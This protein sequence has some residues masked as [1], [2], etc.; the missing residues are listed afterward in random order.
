MMRETGAS[1]EEERLSDGQISALSPYGTELRLEEGD[2]L[3]DEESVVDSFYVVLEG[4]IRISRLDGAAE[5]TLVSHSPG[6]FTGGLATLTGR[7]SVHRARAAVPS[8]VLEIDSETFR[9]VAVEIPDAADVFI[10]VLAQRMRETH[11]ALRQQE[12]LAALGRLSAG[13]AHE[14]NNPAAAAR[15][16]SEGL[17]ET[18]LAAQ[19]NA[20]R[21]DRRFSPAQREALLAL[22]REATE[23]GPAPGLDPLEQSDREEELALWLEER[24]VDEAWDLA[25][26]LAAAGLDTGRMETLEGEFDVGTLAGGLGWLGATLTV[27]ALAEEVGQSA[28]RI[29]ELVAAI[30]D[31]TQM[32]RSQ[33]S[34]ETDVRE[35]IES[36][37]TILGHRLRSI[38]V[39][40]EY[41]QE[42][43]KVRARGGELNQVWSNLIG[44]AADAVSLRDG[45]HGSIGVGA[46][47]DGANHVLVEIRDDG[48]GIPPEIRGRIFEPFFTTRDVGEGTGLGLDIARRAIAGHGGEIDFESR[49]GDTRF[50]VR[51]PVTEKRG[52]PD[53]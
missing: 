10:S 50:R 15:R 52:E 40:R 24:G 53:E 35:G 31:H 48:P 45:G 17:R 32:D 21:H 22:R 46:R 11:R 4:E 42:L 30:K 51:L 38:S 49:P 1:Q 36:T 5:T 39:E 28:G 43:P 26:T 13:L 19:D 29:S 47:R 34:R 18:S 9:R 3:F 2:L 23:A 14:L 20:L 6:E 27:A 8:R 16:A 33:G 37:L 25:P 41:E 12:K 44:N 7:R